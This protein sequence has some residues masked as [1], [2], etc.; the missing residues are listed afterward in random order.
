MGVYK[1][2]PEY[3]WWCCCLY[4]E[5]NEKHKELLNYVT[6]SHLIFPSYLYINHNP[7]FSDRTI[8]NNG[9]EKFDD[10]DI[11][12]VIEM[13]SNKENKE[14]AE[15]IEPLK[16][17]PKKHTHLCFKLASSKPYFGVLR[18]FKFKEYNEEGKIVEDQLINFVMPIYHSDRYFTYL[19]HNDLQS[20]KIGKEKYNYTALHGDTN[21]ITKLVIDNTNFVLKLVEEV[22]KFITMNPDIDS[23]SFLSCVA[24]LARADPVKANILR[25]AYKQNHWLVYNALKDSEFR[26]KYQIDDLYSN[27]PSDE[28]LYSE[29]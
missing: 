23:R 19:L 24:Y 18:M 3:K 14:F 11:E 22:N 1:S 25:E 13:F 9:M 21:I 16:V 6:S 10:I 20:I 27:I 5:E 8:I 12:A 7:E 29:L 15:D 28:Y 2:Y 17:I 26:K 4:P